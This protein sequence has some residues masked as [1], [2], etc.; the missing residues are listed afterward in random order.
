MQPITA[1][2]DVPVT[3]ALIYN[4]VPFVPD[5]ATYR[6][7]GPDDE[8]LQDW[9]TAPSSAVLGSIAITIPASLN[10]LGTSVVDTNGVSQT[11]QN[12]REA[13]VIL[14]NALAADIFAGSQQFSTEYIIAADAPPLV[15]MT[16]SFQAYTD[17]VALANDVWGDLT[18]WPTASR[19]D[20]INAMAL[21]YNFLSRLN[22]EIYYDYDDVYFKQRASWGL[23][24]Q[25]TVGRLYNYSA[26]QFLQ[27]DPD[28]ILCVRKAQ[29]VEADRWLGGLGSPEAER[30]AGVVS[31][32]VGDSTSMY[33][34]TKPL[35]LMVSRKALKYL[36]GYL[37]MTARLTLA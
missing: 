37:K 30:L 28:F 15:I 24:Y 26:D 7:L 1:G 3:V 22:Y 11:V 10:V 23:P 13:R 8:I 32:K 34:P 5:S 35:Q 29:I 36:S 20:R 12:T 6:V 27:L 4:G 18:E 17:S 16:N 33:R 9:T 14:V 2:Q 31:E 21:S 19:S 25:Q